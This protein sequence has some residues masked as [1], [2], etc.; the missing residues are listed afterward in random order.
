MDSIRETNDGTPS[1]NIPAASSSARRLGAGAGFTCVSRPFSFDRQRVLAPSCTAL[2]RRII[3][4][5]RPPGNRFLTDLTQ[6]DDLATFLANRSAL[7]HETDVWADGSLPLEV[8]GYLSAELPPD[9]YVT[10]VR[11]LVFHEDSM[12]VIRDGAGDLHVVPGGRRE[13]GKA[14]EETLYR[15]VLEEAGWMCGQASL[16]GFVHYRHLAPPGRRT[17]RTHPRLHSAHL[18]R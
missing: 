18:S 2:W 9:A 15:E 14:Y 16:L 4:A 8:S 6:N 5:P 11:A 13:P 3:A 10:S 17:T 12:L 1:M 7:W